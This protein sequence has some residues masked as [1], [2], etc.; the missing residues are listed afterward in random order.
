MIASAMPDVGFDSREGGAATADVAGRE[1]PGSPGE[2]AGVRQQRRGE[3]ALAV[4]VGAGTD[5]PAGTSRVLQSVQPAG[6]RTAGGEA[7]LEAEPRAEAIVVLIIDDIGYV[8]Q[9]REEKRKD[10][11]RRTGH[12]VSRHDCLVARHDRVVLGPSAPTA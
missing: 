5:P 10:N 9:S 12:T 2:C 11:C 3:D 7:G 4:C 1:L 6:A 8:Q